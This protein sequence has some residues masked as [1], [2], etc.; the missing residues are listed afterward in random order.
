[1]TG[2][3]HQLRVHLQYLG[4]PIANDPIYCTDSWGPDYARGGLDVAKRVELIEKVSKRGI[5]NFF[6][7][8]LP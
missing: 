7:S 8:R 6:D 3:T 5:T 1:M 4:Y 2:R